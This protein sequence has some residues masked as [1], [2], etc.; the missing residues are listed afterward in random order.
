[1]RSKQPIP[2]PINNILIILSTLIALFVFIK[3]SKLV[4]YDD[5]GAFDEWGYFIIRQHA[6]PLLDELMLWTTFLGDTKFVIIPVTGLFVYYTFINPRK[7]DAIKVLVISIGCT[8]LNLLL[9]YLYGR[10]RPFHDHLVE[11]TNLSFPSGHAM[12]SM[13]FYGGLIYFITKANQRAIVKIISVLLLS[14][15]ILS[16]GI[17]RVYLGVH[18]TSDIVAGFSAGYIWLI[19]VLVGIDRTEKTIGKKNRQHY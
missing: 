2:Y 6:S 16:I 13:A 5:I 3:L 15:I 11:A 19:A 7:W 18:Y 8:S 9:K 14:V 1:M 12:F 17:S 10:E 4:L